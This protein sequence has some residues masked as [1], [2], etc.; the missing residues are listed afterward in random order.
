MTRA[1]LP[2][3]D[4]VGNIGS[5]ARLWR[6]IY[7]NRVTFADGSYMTSA[8][9]SVGN[10]VI[11]QE[12]DTGWIQYALTGFSGDPSTLYTGAHSLG[13]EPKFCCVRMKRV[14]NGTTSFQA[15]DND[16]IMW[17]GENAFSH[18]ESNG[19]HI[20]WGIKYDTTNYYIRTSNK[21]FWLLQKQG[22]PYTVTPG[23]YQFKVVFYR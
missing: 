6:T 21:A 19:V 9:D 5:P 17:V 8:L 15:Y 14:L 13:G 11:T 2:K 7:V 1:I 20:G 10:S 3:T 12:F 18:R 23:D 22:L 4:G 16:D